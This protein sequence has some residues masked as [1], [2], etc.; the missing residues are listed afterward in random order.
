LGSAAAPS[1]SF[2]GNSNT[3]VWSSGADTVNVSTAGSERLT[4]TSAGNVGIGTTSPI[5]PLDLGTSLGNKILL[6]PGSTT[7]SYGFGIQSS[8]LQMFS[9]TGADMAFGTGASSSF[10]E[11]MRI[12][13]S[14]NV[15]IGTTAP[16][17]VLDV[18]GAIAESSG[19]LNVRHSNLT[20]GIS[21]GYNSI[22]ASGSSANQHVNIL[23]KGTGN[24]GIGTT[25][26]AAPLEI[27]KSAGSSPNTT[28]AIFARGSDPGFAMQAV[29]GVS[30]NNG[31]D[32][33]GK[34]GVRYGG[35][36][37]G[38]INFYR[39]AGAG[40]GTMALS[41]GGSDRL[42]VES[43][44]NVGIG[45]TTPAGRLDLLAGGDED[46]PVIRMRQSNAAGYGMDLGIDNNVHG[47]L[48]IRTNNNGAYADAMVIRRDNGNVGI[49]TTAP[50][51]KLSVAGTVE[52]TTGGFKFPDGTVQTTAGGAPNYILITHSLADGTDGG[53]VTASTWNIRPF[54]TEVTDTGGHASV[55]GNVITLAAGTYEC[56]ISSL[57]YE[58]TRSQ[59][60]LYNITAGSVI[61][62]GTVVNARYYTTP[63]SI[64]KTRFTLASQ[65][66]LRVEQNAAAAQATN[67]FGFASD[68]T[69]NPET[70]ATFQ[71][72]RY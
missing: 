29:T 49:G 72:Y 37:N 11:L 39:G 59:A 41:A 43:S 60:R 38:V 45:W 27:G 51:Q 21:I 64:I 33:V 23:P 31:G 28:S 30:T 16:G 57:V 36:D 17:S 67:G 69:G 20:Q 1:Y 34:F 65:S 68:W 71:C 14:G 5:G 70:Y 48:H 9:S 56:D 47:G 15:G 50:T 53:S 18:V 62:Y 4:V 12:K 8:L 19:G 35:T 46:S 44:G 25:A 3:G 58:V 26:P 24:V 32:L 2:T 10:T 52:S 66:N 55:S 42:T 54:N 13:S 22:A 7:N 61:A 6:W 63:A 40:D